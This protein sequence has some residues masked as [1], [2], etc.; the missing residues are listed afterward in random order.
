MIL[1]IFNVAMIQSVYA[2]SSFVLM[3]W[4]ICNDDYTIYWLISTMFVW[5]SCIEKQ[6]ERESLYYLL[7]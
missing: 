5:W 7:K 6:P 3:K 2:D 4:K 1:I